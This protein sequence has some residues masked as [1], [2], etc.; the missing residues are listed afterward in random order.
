MHHDYYDQTL[1]ERR[2][3]KYA[4]VIFLPEHLDNII[5]PVRERFDPLYNLVPS[6]IS[7]VF[8]FES[9]LF[10]DELAPLIK[11]ETE[12]QKKLIVHMNSIGDFYPKY[13]IIYWDV[14]ENPDLKNLYFRLYTALSLSVPYKQ[15]QPH[16]TIAREISNHRLMLVK[17]DVA[18]YLPTERFETSSVDLISPLAGAQWV[19][20][21]TFNLNG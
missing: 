6:H 17:D 5:L 2:R 10:L 7:L 11:A 14:M 16:V 20:V 13:P 19:S 12:K 21:R 4:V 3:K 8:P 1:S 9:D 15:Y 18:P